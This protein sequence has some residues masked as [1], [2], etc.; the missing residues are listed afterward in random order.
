MSLKLLLQKVCS[1]NCTY[2]YLTYFLVAVSFYLWHLD[3]SLSDSNDFQRFS[4]HLKIKSTILQ[5]FEFKIKIDTGLL[6]WTR[7]NL[8][9]YGCVRHQNFQISIYFVIFLEARHQKLLLIKLTRKSPKTQ[10]LVEHS[11][12]RNSNKLSQDQHLLAVTQ[13]EENLNQT[14]TKPRPVW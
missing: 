10:S 4:E 5:D 2:F 14:K 1:A 13:L 8:I 9:P 6:N 12:F 11:T 7:S 3:F